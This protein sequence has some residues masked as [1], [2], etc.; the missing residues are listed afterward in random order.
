GGFGIDGLIVENCVM[1][2]AL[3]KFPEDPS[4]PLT[5]F[6]ALIQLGNG[7]GNEILASNVTVRN[8]V[9]NGNLV[10]T[11]DCLDP[12]SPT[13]TVNA[14]YQRPIYIGQAHAIL[15]DRCEIANFFVISDLNTFAT[16]GLINILGFK[17]QLVRPTEITIR[18]CLA[19]GDGLFNF[20]H[21]IICQ[22]ADN[23]LVEGCTVTGTF[24]GINPGVGTKNMTI[25]DSTVQGT[26]H[27]SIIFGTSD[28]DVDG[29]TI[30]NNH[31]M[32]P[33]FNSIQIVKIGDGV[34]KN[35]IVEG[36]TISNGNA[37]GIYFNQ[38]ENCVARN[39]IVDTVRQVGIPVVNSVNTTIQDNTVLN[40]A[41]G[42]QVVGDE[43]E[44]SNTVVKGNTVSSSGANGIILFN[45]TNTTVEN[46]SSD[47]NGLAELGDGI[48]VASSTKTS[49]INNSCIGNGGG[50]ILIG[51][52]STDTYVQNNTTTQ[53]GIVGLNDDD[54][55]GQVT[56]FFNKSCDNGVSNCINIPFAVA[57][58]DPDYMGANLCCDNP[59]DL[60]G[61]K[62]VKASGTDYPNPVGSAPE[63][64]PAP[65]ISLL[66]QF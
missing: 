13:C 60:A 46:N 21:G 49:L 9:L 52:G 54:N 65:D 32:R 41:E 16:S 51:L 34:I 55:T 2:T 6:A 5:L 28:G 47:Y 11:P 17:D 43:F 14:G 59:D 22:Y 36:N 33:G 23:V 64:E 20:Q 48:V 8:C 25:R 45:A 7:S 37:S 40:T 1:Q 61:A 31:L 15:I 62:K 53:N 39:N 66:P 18:N 57:P 42:I 27:C 12:E 4:S 35:V 19:K 56:A 10:Y 30:A 44:T 58:G 26:G 38:T 24:F 29:V 50:G 3:V 63:S